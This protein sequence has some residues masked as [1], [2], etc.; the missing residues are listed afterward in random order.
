MNNSKKVKIG[1]VILT[2]VLFGSM[3]ILPMSSAIKINEDSVIKQIFSIYDTTEYQ[4]QSDNAETIL[5][6]TNYYP[7]EE[8]SLADDQNDIGY[9]VDAGKT[10]VRSFEVYVGEP[11][12]KT[13]PGRGRDG[14]LDPDGGDEDDWYK[15]SVCEGQS[16]QVSL[17]SAEDFDFELADSTGNPVGQSHT[18][19]GTGLYFLHIFSNDGAGTGD[20]TFGITLGSQNDA[21]TGNDAGNNIGSATSIAPGSYT[22]YM[23][24]NDQEDWYSFN[25]N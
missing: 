6:D 5:L 22:G 23:E 18:A 20:Y 2:A 13:V 4:S 16:I 17:N 10:I 1:A 14:T 11:V 8:V 25:A 19:L 24:Y 21:G 7:V 3:L 12:D 9:N 15:F